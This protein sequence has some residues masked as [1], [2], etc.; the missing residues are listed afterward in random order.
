MKIAVL[1]GGNGSFAAAGDFALSGH[2]VRLW[3]RDA[4]QVAAHR[5]TGS[6][7]LVQDHNGRHDVKLA[8]VTTDIAK[9]VGGAELVLC[10]APAFAQPDIARLLAPHLEDDQVV[11]L[12]PATFGSMIF[13][14]AARDAG[15]RARVSFAETGTLPWLTR[16]HGPFEVAITIRAK[17]LPVGVFPLDQA[18]HA[19]QVIGRAFPS[20]IEGC[21]DAL[22]GAL[23]NAGPIIHPP[24][25]VMNAGPIEHFDRW[26]I[27]KEGTQ[28]SIRRVTD[29]LDAE[30]I[31]VREALGYSA[32]HFPLAHHYAKEGEIWMYGRGS[33]DRLTDSGD[34]RERIVL[35]DHRYMREDLRLGLSLLV[36]VAELAGVATPLAQAFL[37]MGGSICG[38]DFAKG[39][40]TLE[41]LG[42]G[43]LSK[44]Q[45][46]ELLRRGF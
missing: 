42:L 20:V 14:Q 19:L 32:P 23:M 24:L 37:A 10:P 7:I 22:S 45:L 35:T 33:H 8:L 17:R 25:I 11:F 4:D 38:E 43:S 27:H 40:R 3:R 16:K 28:G 1:G 31:A 41:A 9:V 12:P 2:E 44:A 5:A 29:A 36:S 21:G 26:D 13:A 6:R 34:W 39:G 30:R 15:N 18:P 46:Q